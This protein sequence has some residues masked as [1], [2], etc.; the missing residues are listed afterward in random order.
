M[1]CLINQSANS[2]RYLH[3]T[4][5]SLLSSIVTRAKADPTAATIILSAL[6]SGNG[7]INFDTLTRSKTIQTI[8]MSAD[9]CVLE[10]MV[11]GF[12]DLIDRPSTRDQNVADSQREAIADQLVALIGHRTAK[13]SGTKSPESAWLLLII[14]TFTRNGY[15]YLGPKER[16]TRRPKPPISSASQD[17]FKSRLWSSLTRIIS[18]QSDKEA[19]VPFYVVSKIGTF[20]Y[21]GKDALKLDATIR[22]TTDRARMTLSRINLQVRLLS[23]THVTFAKPL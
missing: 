17:M 18:T 15:V 21:N 9:D 14:G 10:D 6:T 11:H 13:I 19:I 16:T 4:A 8:L 5:E 2:E 22:V 12:C 1:K 23:F 20:E 3:N 7:T